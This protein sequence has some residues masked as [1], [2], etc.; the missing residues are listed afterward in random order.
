MSSRKYTKPDPT[1]E[2][3]QIDTAESDSFEPEESVS[4]LETPATKYSKAEGI[5]KPEVFIVVFSNGE[6]REKCYF[7][8]IQRNCPK[9]RLEFFANPISPDDLLKDVI[10]KKA[11]YASTTDDDTPDT[12]YTVTD[13]DH[14][15][16]DIVR[17]KPLYQKEDIRLI[18]SNPCF[19]VWLYYSKCSDK[20]DGFIMPANQLKLSQEVKRFLNRKISG[21]CNP[22]KAIFD[23]R[24][25][26]NNA[27]KNYA[28]DA[29]QIPS[30][31]ATNMFLLAQDILP[32]IIAE[33]NKAQE[34]SES[35]EVFDKESSV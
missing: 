12:Y 4:S 1:K 9:L 29:Q 17:S 24:Q 32:Y 2:D 10:T 14:F 27:Q 34:K 5:L 35:N 11:V 16:N 19:E 3:V 30:L 21:G 28:V 15:Y 33:L 26:I 8:W 7:Q 23:I 18:V 25:N 6:V 13:V 31:F 20:F 22:K